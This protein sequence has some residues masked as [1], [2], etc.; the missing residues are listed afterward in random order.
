MRPPSPFR[1]PPPPQHEVRPPP[2]AAARGGR[3]ARG[4]R[5]R[6]RGGAARGARESGTRPGGPW[7]EARSHAAAAPPAAA[8]VPPATFGGDG[9][10]HGHGHGRSGG[11]GGDG[12]GR[13]GGGSHEAVDSCSTEPPTVVAD[14]SEPESTAG[15]SFALVEGWGD[16][17]PHLDEYIRKTQVPDEGS[18]LE[19][20]S[21]LLTGCR[22]EELGYLAAFLA[23]ACR[24]RP[25][26]DGALRQFVAEVDRWVEERLD[27]LFAPLGAIKRLLDREV[28]Q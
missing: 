19:Y 26:W 14:C 11:G 5:G 17:W 13:G 18:L 6:A 4:S 10:V 7:A 16:V 24:D 8:P 27:G 21:A 20:A 28:V 12:D 1:P 22:L 9:D 2:P 15:S 23:R 25:R 3:G